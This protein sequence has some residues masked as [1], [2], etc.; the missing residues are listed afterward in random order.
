M[1]CLRFTRTELRLSV[2]T[3]ANMHHFRSLFL[4]CLSHLPAEPA[5]VMPFEYPNA[6]IALVAQDGTIF[7]ARHMN[8]QSNTELF[9]SMAEIAAPGP[10]KVGELPSLVVDFSAAGLEFVLRGL[11]NVEL[12]P[13]T[14]I[15]TLLEAYNIAQAW[16]A[17]RLL[18][19]IRA[20]I[21]YGSV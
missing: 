9:D 17:I 8:L 11:H 7:K 6:D 16:S 12:D 10:E 1:L 19:A 20:L 15:E 4:R 5:F 21:R 13:E 2:L 18:D 14:S 3:V